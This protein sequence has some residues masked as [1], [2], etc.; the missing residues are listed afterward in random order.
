MNEIK[1]RLKSSRNWL[2]LIEELEADA[3]KVKNR[4]EKSKRLYTLGQACEELFLRKDKAMVSY[5]KAFK[6]HPQNVRPLE[7]ARL[8]Y[9][10]MGNLKMV[11][12]L[13]DFQ[14]K[15][16]RDE[17]QRAQL[18]T[19]LAFTCIDLRMLDAAREKINEAHGADPNAEGLDE[20][21]ATVSY[22]PNAWEAVISALMQQ[23]EFNGA[24][25]GSPYRDGS[26]AT[27]E[28]SDKA[29]LLVR[30]AR[31]YAIQ[32]PTDPMREQLLA[33]AVE[34]D[35]QS[36]S[37]NFLYETLLQEQGRMAEIT[38]LHEKRVRDAREEDR[39]KLYQELASLWAIRFVDVGT[40][41]TFYERA[42]REF[43]IKGSDPFPG[44]LAAFNFLKDVKGPQGE[45]AALLDLFDL[46]LEAPL[47][48]DD[49][50]VLATMAGEV[51]Y[52]E[53]KDI[54]RASG[55]FGLVQRF[56]PDNSRLLEF[57]GTHPEAQI[58]V[59]RAAEQQAQATAQALEAVGTSTQI[60]DQEDID[61]EA[62]AVA[63]EMPEPPADAEVEAFPVEPQP[64]AAEVEIAAEEPSAEVQ[65]FEAEA[66]DEA[67]QGEQEAPAAEIE[68]DEPMDE[69]EGEAAEEPADEEPAEVAADDEA[70]AQEETAEEAEDEAG[71]EAADDEA[72]E[73]A[74]GDEADDEEAAATDDDAADEPAEVAAAPR[75]AAD[76]NEEMDDA[77]RALCDEAAEAEAESAERGIEA[78]RKVA[79]RQRKLRTPRR[80]LGRL[81]REQE[82]WN[83]LVEVLK[84]EKDL[85]DDV[86][87]K[88]A[89]L[90][91][92]AELYGEHLRLD[93]M[94]VNTLGELHKLDENDVAVID[95]L[96]EQ[97]EKMNR[98]TDLIASLKKKAEV[99]GD[100][101]EQVEI[102]TRIATLF[103]ERFSNQAEAIKAYEQILELD[104]RNREAM[105]ELKGMYERRRDW[106]KLIHVA[107]LEID[108][109]ESDDERAAAYVEVAQ[110]ATTKVKRP[111]ISMELWEKVVEFD[112]NNIEALSSL[113]ALYERNKDW[114]KL[115]DVCQR[116]VTL[117]DDPENKAQILQKLGILFSDKVSD[118]ARAIDAW[119]ELLEIEP[120]NRRAQDS[121]KKLYLAASAYQELEAFYASQDKYD[122]YIRVLER[123][124]DS[125]A[126]EMQL[127]LYFKIAELWQNKLEKPDRAAR[128][129]EKVL[130][131][132]EQNLRAAEALIPIYEGGRDVKKYVSVL[133]IQLT[134][135]DEPTLQLERI[136]ALAELAE[137]RLRDK[138]TAF[139]W[140]LKAFEVDS[141]ADWIRE[142]AERL[143]GEVG[144]WPELVTAYEASYERIA[145]PLDQLPIMLT[146]AR[147]F[148]EQLANTEEALRTNKR[149]VEIEPQNEQAIGALE[150]LY[151]ATQQW[152]ELL[153]IYQR[154]IEMVVDPEERKEIYFRTAFLYE[155]EIAD[156]DRAIDAYRT[157]LD[158]DGNDTRALKA[159]DAMYQRLE[160]W[161]DLGE[162][163]L[164]QLELVAPDDL[165]GTIE[166]KFR[167]GKLRE[168]HLDAVMGAVEAYRDIL[169]MQPDH[170]GARMALEERLE[171]E[172]FQ[173]DVSM[174]LEPIYTQLEEWQRLVQVHEIQLSRQE[175]PLAKVDLLLRIGGLWVEKIGDGEQAFD[176]YSRCFKVE[177]TNEM[178]RGELERLAGIAERWDDLASLYESATQE[179]L[180]AP[181]LHELL[182][183][184]A[185]I[186]DERLERSERAVEFYRRAQE[187]E[188]EHAGT[189]D[190]LERLYQKSEQ[191]NELLEIYRRKADLSLDAEE[192]E[193]LF[194][195]M[196]YIWEEMLANLP[197][198]VSC[199]NEIL[200]QEDGN[201]D[202]LRALDRLYQAQ[203]AWHELADNLTRQ[204]ALAEESYEKV[205]F[206]VRLARLRE[207]E[208]GELA[209]A[210]DT[211]RQV[212]ELDPTNAAAVQSLE[213]LIQNEEHQL[214]V[215]QILEPYYK[216]AADWQ[217]LVGVY[218]IMVNHAFDPARKIELLHQIAELYELAGEDPGSA[219]GVFG[220]ALRED[221]AHESTQQNLER[222]ARS[223]GGWEHLV[224]L[225]NELVADVMDEML[226]VSLH[227]KV[228]HIWEVELG[229]LGE[230]AE[231]YKRILALDPQN[232]PAVGALEQIY[233]RSEQY[234][235][236]VGILLKRAEIV[237]DAEERKQ[238]FFRAAQIN[239]DVLEELDKAIDVYRMILDIDDSEAQALEAL[240][241]LFSRLE[242]W[243]DLKEIYLRKAELTAEVED[244]KT[245]Y[246]ALG[247][248]YVEQLADV[249]RAIETFQSVVDLDPED[250]TAIRSLD[251]LFQQAARWYD[252]LQVLERQVE[253]AGNSPEGIDLKHRI[254]KLWEH[255]LGDLTRAVE[256]YRDVLT[257]DPVYQPTLE[258]LDAIVHGA[259]EPVLAAQVL[260]P[261]YEQSLEWVKLI[262]LFEVMVKNVD[263]PFRKIELLHRIA[264]L[265]ELRV[266]DAAK[267]FE[268]NGRALTEDSA[269]ER[270]LANLERLAGDIGGW[271]TLAQLYE[272]EL[273]KL[274]DPDRQVEMGLRVARVYE[275]ELR[276]SEQA[277]E[278][279]KRVLEADLENRDA[280]LSLDRLYMEGGQWTELVEILRREIRMADAE[281][282]IIALHFRLGQLYQEQ[283]QD[284]PNAIECYREILASTPDHGSSITSLELLFSEG[285]HQL[286]IAE[287]LEPLYR[288]SEQWERLVKIM[289]VQL[290]RQEDPFE[291]V[292]AIQRIAEIC[293]QR[294]GDH[295]RAFR[296]WGYSLQF[297][298]MAELITEELERLARMVD[299]W[300][301]LATF[302]KAVLEGL[303][304]DDR[305][306]MLKMAARVYD[307]ELRDRAQAEEAYLRVLQ[308]DSIDADALEALDRIYN[309]ASM[310]QELAEILKRRIA[311]TDG[312]EELVELQLRL[313]ATY[314]TALEEFENAIATY[315]QVLE[316]DSRNQ[317]ALES[318]EQI[319]FRQQQWAELFD[320]YEKMI[321]IAPGDAGVAD[322]YAR[323]AK[324]S[325]DALEN[326]ERA[327]DLWNRV[328]DLRGEDPVALWAL[329][330]LYEAAEEWRELV[331][332]LQRQVHITDEPH[333]QIRLYQRL[334]RIWGDKLSR[335][336][337]ALESWQKVLEID[338]S[339]LTAL[340]AIARI[341]RE[342]QA[343]EEL[344][345][346]LH[347]LIDIGITSDM[348]D[349]D[350]KA[351]Y[352]Q[353]GEL[354]GE[355]LL[356]PQEAVEA[357]RKVLD[358]QPDSFQALGALEQL[359]T[360]E[361][362]W[363]ECIQVLEKK[364][365]VV[366][367]AREKIDVLMQAANI[368]QEKVGNNEAAGSVYE[369]I[370]ELEAANRV[371][372]TALNQIYREGW[373]WEKLVDL[374]LARHELTAELHEKVELL[375]EVAKIYEAHLNQP[376]GAFMVLQAAFELDYTNDVTVK[377]LERLASVT[378]QWN[379]LLTKCNTVVQT[380]PDPKIKSNLLVNMGIW[381]GS[382]LARLD[383]A[384]AS[385]QQ[386]L[387]IDPENKRALAALA[388]FFRKTGQWAELVQVVNRHQ[389][390]ED[391][392]PK[393]TDLLS[394]MAEVFEMQL[395]DQPQA[396]NAYRKA[397]S[398]DDANGDVLNALERLYRNNENWEG[399][400]AILARKAELAE[401][402]REI[403]RLR[404]NIGDLYEDQLARLQDAIGAHKDVLIVE[405]QHLPALKALERLYGKT[406]QHDDYL[407]VLEQQLD[408]ASG[409][410]E[411]ISLHQRQATVWEEQFNKLDRATECL[412]KILLIDQNHVVT[413]R[414]L[415]RLYQ[416]DGRFDDLVETFRR[417]INAITDPHERV[418]LYLAM[419]QTYEA[420]LQDPDRAIEAYTDIL[421]FDPDHTQ[422][423]DALARLYEDIEAWDRAVDVMNRLVQL[424]DDAAYRVNVFFRLGRIHEE[425]LEDPHTAE[426]RYSQALELH[427]GHVE[428][429][430]QLVEI[431]KTRGDW[432]KAANLMVRAEAHS[433]NSLDKARLLYEAGAAYLN[434]LGDETT[435]AQLLA[436]TLE[437]DP[438][439]EQ[440]GEPLAFLYFRDERYQEVEPVLDMLIRKAD[441][442]DNRRL[443][444]LYYKLGKSC[445]VLDKSEKALKYYRAA[446]DIDST[447]LPTLLGMADLLH[448]M[449]DW[450]RAFKIYQTILVHHR[451]SQ[452]SDEIVEIFY[453]LGNIKLK[454]GER[455]K[456]LNMFEKALEINAYHRSTLEAVVELQAKH[457]DW[458]S[459]VQAK[460]ALLETADIDEKF[461][462]YGDLGDIFREKLHSP[463]R[464]IEALQAATELKPESHSVLHKLIELFSELRQWKRAVEI[465]VQ[466]ADMESNERIKARYFYS[467]AV[468][469]RDEVKDLDA[470]LE[471][472]NKSLDHQLANIDASAEVKPGD[473]KAFE[474]MDRICTQ[475]K[476][477]KTQE[478]NYRKMIK[479]LSPDGQQGIKVML[480]HALGE[481]YRSRLRDF[482]SAVAAF[483]VSSSLEPEN[484]QRH[485]IL[486]ELYVLAGPDYADKAITE[487]QTLIKSSPF[488]IDSYQALR[489]IYMD[490]KHYD[491][492]WCLCS[493]LSFLK[494]ADAEEQQFYEQYKQ[495]GFVRARARMTDEMWRRDIFHADEDVYVGTIFSAIA[496]VVGAMTAQPHKKFGL[497][498]KE[499]RDLATDSLLFSKVFNYVTSVLNVV[500][501]DLYL[502]PQRP[503]GLQMA[504]TTEAPSFVVGQDLLQGRPEKELG[505]AI[506]KELTNL[507]PE[508]FLRRVL[509][510]ASQLRTVFFSAL[511]M[512]NPQF[513]IPPADVPEVDKIIKSVR[514]GM[515]AGQLEMLAGV[516]NRFIERRG[517]VNLNKWLMGVE[518]TS[519]RVGFVLCNDL[520]VAAKM[521]STEPAAIGGLPPK[522][523]VK[524][525]VLYSVS[526]E[527]FRVRNDLGLTI[528]Q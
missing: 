189:L 3:E 236:L 237:L 212:L 455:K 130:S 33:A 161:G 17:Q 478:R 515:H 62:R 469:N 32:A 502:Q 500:Q 393:R 420:S 465:V 1:Q 155:E 129:Y 37:A 226:A 187:L 202:A 98:W 220:R 412:E 309:Q 397:L 423:L 163:L 75:V 36:E 116:Q 508:H 512:C 256:T 11:A 347:R 44:H 283:L 96:V 46:A 234:P 91:E 486:A 218:E 100:P 428:S 299:G 63:Q 368:W 53:L 120:E 506:S 302:Y 31:I 371:A 404:T 339:D 389:E 264:E 122:E 325:S 111:Q 387:Q 396:I 450:D 245:I 222:L 266:E 258:A 166:L 304:D 501:A 497:K 29:R 131:L 433:A 267:S 109:L 15:V 520:E 93:V 168:T 424:V 488:K 89:M 376:A 411:R 14:L 382:E 181:L 315:T 366:A 468:I 270:A 158:I 262:D 140:Y 159:L 338:P 186:M 431:Y 195:K 138:D 287:I 97:Y 510:A 208:L 182:L 463:E 295:E 333:A 22:D 401:E 194:S 87:E 143:A 485:E 392:P 484:M 363:E 259:E 361:A 7:R 292:Q 329:A 331:E 59:D 83:Q 495:R 324:I 24:S 282:D 487:H 345:E 341:F 289:E 415:A 503:A 82:R 255:E 110:L 105:G 442:R 115:A 327:Q 217:K 435:A 51:A 265:Y 379:E 199:Y 56:E 48:E 157:I 355:I 317:Q 457:S 458:E 443:Q 198:A 320:V 337:N 134:H 335:E 384:V 86:F 200:A 207:T 406:A 522:E 128:A 41:A 260:E 277:I 301:E 247:R 365:L 35:P 230:A 374:L 193:R 356:R 201:L 60:V 107:Q 370:L 416:V 453:R 20:A 73:E 409:D 243:E 517:E 141:R 112:P 494:K 118:D 156:A 342:T 449:E 215:A 71:E 49:M 188:P 296:W 244:K 357:W 273:D 233:L 454:L 499:R 250:L 248:L 214:T 146:V 27:P 504:H 380:I 419:G 367:D 498:R 474:A 19:S 113:E 50:I 459:V 524:E 528:G 28:G 332:V 390:L 178:A 314:E 480:W 40:T 104:P 254:G 447:H 518:L 142:E 425:H 2:A 473:L 13:M 88:K 346:T 491:K 232:L 173:L 286:E 68:A 278:H 513:P 402:P 358:L 275:E 526:E 209:A 405:P 137:Q 90:L 69:S 445:D 263:D 6:L 61:Q 344:V 184:L 303:D 170:E 313:G 119:R 39:A 351:L 493:T 18:L 102:W 298:P 92:M 191:W 133:E 460:R 174:I 519:N 147:V 464:A 80:A 422:A 246:Y 280:I 26:A 308:I 205:D 471:F 65:S 108:L 95:Q 77:T 451:D 210:V 482:P 521:V 101:L 448:R 456:A 490:I 240:E 103:V 328:L 470:S 274:L 106:D 430:M 150:R 441:R 126:P 288:M 34:A 58:F 400:I 196:A 349:D 261:V 231:A 399:L 322:C 42:L 418:Q 154:K 45:W 330:D 426:E 162:A 177:P 285:Q 216:G 241:R 388:D 323:M 99:C 252:L 496:P 475:R 377:E 391:D 466:L 145:D 461:V 306:R 525:L 121:L 165:E 180:D 235:E 293:E 507:R 228:A 197:E 417:H 281:Q 70:V 462:I 123:Q 5:Q 206:L 16:E 467:A 334:G 321:D 25:E 213:G 410:D 378:N 408:I 364:V 66:A 43:Y 511:K 114:D 55:F 8:I 67:E 340:Y 516:V 148:E 74:A 84:E 179:A 307:E 64:A 151:T 284:L 160:R 395:G 176:A 316:S 492:A 223:L 514:A 362:R 224:A 4:E 381:Y 385:V 12:K 172:K 434:E 483:E 348:S 438:D 175:D 171:D 319:Y 127:D 373:H 489:R 268:A 153:E 429:M 279:F 439:H 305:R 311:I 76:I 221:P 276:Q 257:S 38:A 164:R 477:W 72:A 135:T 192:R 290:E 481:I 352:I 225:Y 271:E 509:P 523:K 359:L 326:A 369:R 227:M 353:L 57:L 185:T 78:W 169:E 421:S 183:K 139:D 476:D 432:A 47:L 297:D 251:A 300:S 229:N 343:W 219:F 310:F 9:H 144:K 479:R 336:R 242:R 249:D 505:F 291:K 85:V 203:S 81:Y 190:A 149:I 403:I 383:Y 79:Q 436:R 360:Q 167:L 136:R 124:V 294:L 398:I 269:D 10:E 54:E 414:S 350:L 21:I 437:I 272:R 427:P 394:A 52:Q 152:T 372:F 117:I 318:L 312:T 30:A 23:A 125:E 446:Y 527:Y 386:A 239:E 440:A 94:V 472:F 444:D 407:D 204:L 413:Y 211:Y 354:Q 253:L 238:L 452:G 132:D 375:Q